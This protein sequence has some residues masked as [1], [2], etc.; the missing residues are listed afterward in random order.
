MLNILKQWRVNRIVKGR[1]LVTE[2]NRAK[3]IEMIMQMGGKIWERAVT[4]HSDYQQDVAALM[5]L[6]QQLED[7][8]APLQRARIIGRRGGVEMFHAHYTAALHYMEAALHILEAEPSH[9]TIDEQVILY[10]NMGEVYRVVG[11]YGRAA[12]HYQIAIEL[13]SANPAMNHNT[14][15]ISITYTNIGLV[16]LMLNDLDAAEE[17]LD[18][19]ITNFRGKQVLDSIGMVEAWRGIAEVRL[20]RGNISG[21][22]DALKLAQTNAEHHHDD[23]HLAACHLTATHILAHDPD[24]PTTAADHLEQAIRHVER[25]RTP[26]AQAVVWLEEAYYQRRHGTPAAATAFANRTRAIFEANG[27]IEGIA[28]AARV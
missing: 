22:W 12:D 17:A 16:N 2:Q 26:S 24:N 13:F 21:A 5:R 15:A 9:A 6:A 25:V 4:G 20:L 14:T 1:P 10:N 18:R 28:I 27:M 11:D 7:L 3:L 23:L 8:N 19:A